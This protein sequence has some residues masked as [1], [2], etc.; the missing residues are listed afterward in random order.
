MNPAVVVHAP[1]RRQARALQFAV[2]VLA[3]HGREGT[4]RRLVFGFIEDHPGLHQREIARLLRL[5]PSNVEYHLRQLVRAGLVQAENDAGFVRYYAT[6]QSP[7]GVSR[8][9][10]P[11]SR[12]ERKCLSLLRQARP[13]EIVAHLLLEETLT[14]GELANRMGIAPATL[15]YQVKKLESVGLV[16]RY[17][18][19][20]ERRV[21]LRAREE[22]VRLLLDHEP[23]QDLVAGFEDLWDE[24]EL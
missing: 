4:S 15:T 20:N 19:G 11:V 23:P 8:P 16:E 24:L 1:A 7:D 3:A 13:L 2:L 10:G 21:R 22:V 6:V 5:T 18:D 9:V 12:E 17:R 14:L